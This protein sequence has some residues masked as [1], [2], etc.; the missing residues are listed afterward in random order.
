MKM[1]MQCNVMPKTSEILDITLLSHYG[2]LYDDVL[3]QNTTLFLHYMVTCFFKYYIDTI[4][5]KEWPCIIRKTDYFAFVAVQH[6]TKLFG[7]CIEMSE[8]LQHALSILTTGHVIKKYQDEF[9]QPRIQQSLECKTTVKRPTKRVSH[10]AVLLRLTAP[11]R[12]IRRI[13]VQIYTT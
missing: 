3:M 5:C 7:G 6:E 10:L 2:V 4:W 11:R 1:W 12:P 8:V 9:R 13:V